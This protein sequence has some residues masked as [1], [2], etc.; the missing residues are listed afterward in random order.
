MN[1]MPTPRLLI[2]QLM[3]SEPLLSSFRQHMP[4]TISTLSLSRVSERS[5]DMTHSTQSSRRIEM[6]RKIHLTTTMSLLV[7]WLKELQKSQLQ[8]LLKTHMM[9]IQASQLLLIRVSLTMMQMVHLMIRH[10][11]GQRKEETLQHL[12]ESLTE[13]I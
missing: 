7:L 8:L 10:Q 4:L 9:E 2:S 11:T 5:S 12:L 1:L 6:K 13:R 3:R